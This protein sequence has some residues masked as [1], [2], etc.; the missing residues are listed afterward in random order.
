[1]NVKELESR[2]RLLE[3]EQDHQQQ[4]LAKLDDLP[5]IIEDEN[6]VPY[7]DKVRE[8]EVANAPVEESV[9]DI[10]ISELDSQTETSQHGYVICLMFNPKSPSE[11][12]T[13]GGGGWRQ[14]GGGTRYTQK[15]LVKAQ[16]TKL[17]KQWPDYPLKVIKR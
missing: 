17:K 16:Y 13:E 10:D 3:E 2:L 6:Y 11:W 4:A 14:K 7:T 1:M 8:V 9:K 12:S 5:R 15:E